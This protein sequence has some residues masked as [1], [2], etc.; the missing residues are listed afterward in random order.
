MTERWTLEKEFRFEASHQL[1]HHDG[2]CARLHGHSWVGRVGIS[3]NYLI[4]AGPKQGMLMDYADLSAIVK[5]IVERSL[6]HWHLN[7]TLMHDGP[8]SEIIA[9]WMWARVAV[10]LRLILRDNVDEILDS[11]TVTIEETCTSRCTYQV[12]R[13]T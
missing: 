5:P 9:Q 4:Q 8:T 3:G 12:I 6:D 10:E 2:R 7:E 13:G 11:L 1:T